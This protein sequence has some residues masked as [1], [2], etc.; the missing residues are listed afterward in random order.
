MVN[1][2]VKIYCLILPFLIT[3]SVVPLV[4]NF[5]LKFNIV[6]KPSKRK[7]H[8]KNI[9]RL[10]GIAIFLGLYITIL[11][12]Q[13]LGFITIYEN[14]VIRAIFICAP[15]FFTLGLLDDIAN[16][17]PFVRLFIQVALSIFAWYEGIRVNS[18]QLTLLI[19]E[20]LNII[21]FNSLSLFFTVF[22][23]VG[24]INAIN[25]MDGLD[26]LAIGII[27]ISTFGLIG[28]SIYFGNDESLNLLI[29]FLG[30]CMA[31]LIFNVFPAK[32]LMGDGGSY[33]LGF[34]S[35]SFAVY[36]F[37]P[38][39]EINSGLNFPLFELLFIFAIPIADMV[40]VIFS[41]LKSKKSVFLPDR[42]HI[43]HRFLDIGFSHK[44]TV[45]LLLAFSQLFMSLSLLITF[46]K[47]RLIIASLS[48]FIFFISVYSKC[49][50]R[51]LLS[52]KLFPKK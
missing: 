10:G 51:K 6:D 18:L 50:Q 29:I 20:P 19:N 9:V 40:I 2:Y 39:A 27:I 49:D 8:K 24:L 28:K 33:L 3:L 26:G 7:Q 46:E 13:S 38:S 4:N 25:W 48:L 30:A 35:A 23:L 16:L 45:L 43:H 1:L 41:R 5:S 42:N 32:I 47:N 22:W 11:L 37:T 36:S 12:M 14:S 34:L 31:F 15:L 52:L 17:S 44:D 21:I